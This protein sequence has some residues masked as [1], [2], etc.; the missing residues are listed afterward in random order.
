MFAVRSVATTR[1]AKEAKAK[2]VKP[3]PVATSRT[4]SVGVGVAHST[5]KSRLVPVA[6]GRLSAYRSAWRPNWAL[7]FSTISRSMGLILPLLP[8]SGNA[9]RRG[10]EKASTLLEGCAKLER[11]SYQGDAWKSTAFGKWHC[12]PPR[13]PGPSCERDWSEPESSNTKGTRTS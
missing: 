6:C 4:R 5:I 2:A 1:R 13:R 9:D 12:G 3:V 7:T 8:D 11:H 10:G